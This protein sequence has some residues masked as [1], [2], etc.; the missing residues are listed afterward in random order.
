MLVVTK[1]KKK[2]MAANWFSFFLFLKM[3]KLVGTQ[4]ITNENYRLLSYG[5]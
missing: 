1:L 4:T 5:F 3:N 2:N